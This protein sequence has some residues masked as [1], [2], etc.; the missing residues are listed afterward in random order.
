MT[1]Q[2][3]VVEL[4]DIEGIGSPDDEELGEYPLDT[5]LIRTESRTIHDKVDPII[6][7]ARG[8]N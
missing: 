8:L 7:T 1:D 4:D 5:M 6:K 3:S 2:Q